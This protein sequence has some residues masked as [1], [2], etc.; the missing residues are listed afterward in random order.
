MELPKALKTKFRVLGVLPW[1]NSKGFPIHYLLI[2]LMYATLIDSLTFTLWFLLWDVETF[3][4]LAQSLICMVVGIFY[5]MIYTRVIWQRKQFAAIIEDVE[6]RI[7]S[8]ELEYFFE[9]FGHLSFR[10]LILA[11]RSNFYIF[12]VLFSHLFS[13]F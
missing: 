12:S 4:E 6:Q 9:I 1:P 3:G 13:L 2:V 5:M 7:N 8:S 10:W 11:T